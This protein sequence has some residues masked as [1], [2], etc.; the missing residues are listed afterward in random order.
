MDFR[1]RASERLLHD[2]D[3]AGGAPE[4]VVASGLRAH[5]RPPGWRHR[6]GCVGV[7]RDYHSLLEGGDGGVT[8]M[9]GG[10]DATSSLRPRDRNCHIE[11][12]VLDASLGSVA[13]QRGLLQNP[14]MGQANVKRLRSYDCEW[15][16]CLQQAI[17]C[18]MYTGHG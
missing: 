6:A 7:G 18:A 12:G 17:Y 5:P 10:H 1:I 2:N 11:G 13:R 15:C 8:E 3:L 14:S 16:P 4:V 9:R